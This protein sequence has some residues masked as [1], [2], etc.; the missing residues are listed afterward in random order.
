MITLT[1]ATK[2]TSRSVDWFGYSVPARVL[3]VAYKDSTAIYTYDAPPS[4]YREMLAAPSKGV[5]ANRLDERYTYR[6]ITSA[7][8]QG[9][10]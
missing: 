6:R 3:V 10:P 5:F 8:V 7:E 9:A 4:A 1:D 2:A